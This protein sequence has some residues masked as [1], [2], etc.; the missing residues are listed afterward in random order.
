M[1][2][3]YWI[4]FII[5]G[6]NRKLL[7]CDRNAHLPRCGL[8]SISLSRTRSFIQRTSET[9]FLFCI[10]NYITITSPFAILRWKFDF[11]LDSGA[12][13][14]VGSGHHPTGKNANLL[15]HMSSSNV[16]LIT[17]FHR[18]SGSSFQRNSART[19]NNMCRN[20]NYLIR[21]CIIYSTH[22]S[23]SFSLSKNLLRNAICLYRW[24]KLSERY[25]TENVR[26][27]SRS[28]HIYSHLDLAFDIDTWF[29][30]S[31]NDVYL[32]SKTEDGQ[33]DSNRF[34]PFRKPRFI[35]LRLPLICMRLNLHFHLF[36][37][38]KRKWMW[39]CYTET[40]FHID[41]IIQISTSNHPSSRFHVSFIWI[42]STLVPNA[43]RTS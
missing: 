37:S 6:A 9:M 5:T 12:C 33:R 20:V 32:C 23:L 31:T 41:P 16:A 35:V 13:W 34:E 10:D 27:R 42:R 29:F 24:K 18:F 4:V 14:A 7:S 1:N 40:H 8:R 39:V 22:A 43:A 26:M 25:R 15:L 17:Y 2:T 36:A 28:T 11:C 19:T 21:L 3:R 30:R 38:G